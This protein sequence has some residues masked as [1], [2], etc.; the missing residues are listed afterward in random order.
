MTWQLIK[1]D[2]LLA[3]L[4]IIYMNRDSCNVRGKLL[5]A[6][7]KRLA[8]LDDNLDEEI[9]AR[10]MAGMSAPKERRYEL[11]DEALTIIECLIVCF[12]IGSW[13]E[14]RIRA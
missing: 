12:W 14:R 4:I 3:R 10:I 9:L 1:V 5:M 7:V 6:L 2:L 13:F 8:F 11:F